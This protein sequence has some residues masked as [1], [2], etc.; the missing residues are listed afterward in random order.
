[1]CGGRA[2]DWLIIGPTG[3]WNS[4]CSMYSIEVEAVRLRD[5]DV[6]VGHIRYAVQNELADIL[7]APERTDE[8]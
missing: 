4:P 3:Y 8:I 7:V 6:G 1:M 2:S 5:G